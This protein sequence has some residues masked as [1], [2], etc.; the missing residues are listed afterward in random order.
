MFDSLESA[1]L[2]QMLFRMLIMA[3]HQRGLSEKR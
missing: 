2:Y 3:A 1:S